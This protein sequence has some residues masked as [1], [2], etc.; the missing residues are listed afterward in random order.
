M[1]LAITPIIVTL[2][3]LAVYTLYRRR[4]RYIG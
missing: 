3:A 1:L 2:L 4:Y